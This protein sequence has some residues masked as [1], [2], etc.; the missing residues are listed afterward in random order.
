MNDK[1]N[2]ERL[3]N[4]E[5]DSDNDSE[6]EKEE[7]KKEAEVEN[8]KK[9][10]EADDEEEE[11]DQN[12]IN[13]KMTQ[14]KKKI[15]EADE[16]FGNSDS[17]NEDDE[18]NLIKRKHETSSNEDSEDDFFTRKKKANTIQ[19]SDDEQEE[20]ND[21][22]ESDKEFRLKKKKV[23]LI[24]EDDE[25]D[26]EDNKIEKELKDLQNDNDDNEEQNEEEKGKAE[27]QQK[28]QQEVDDSNKV[29]PDISSSSSEDEL[30][31]DRNGR[32]SEFVY[33][34][35]LMM[36][37]RKEQNARNRKRR[38]TDLI[39]DSD[40]FI[41]E[42]L[43]QMKH[44]AD[45]DFELNKDHKA[46][47]RKMKLL[48]TVATFL[49]KIDL[50]ESFLDSGVLSVITDWLTPLPDR[51]L[52]N[53]QIREIMLKILLELNIMDI[54]RLKSSSIGKAVMY[55]Y[56]HPKETKDNKRKA[57]QLISNWSRPIFNCETDY[58]A[59]SKEDRE[60][61]DYDLMHK[62]VQRRKGDESATSS[63]QATAAAAASSIESQSI[64]R[65]GEKGWMPR[66]RVPAPSTKDYVV[67]PKSTVDDLMP[68]T[69]SSR[70]QSSRLDKHLRS[71]Q[72]KKRSSKMQRAVKMSI[73]GRKI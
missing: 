48:P 24:E 26:Q 18:S 47:T 43:N 29:L 42:L 1:E 19:D 15:K 55:L 59:I 58:Q 25:D 34:F 69:K 38:N 62:V 68:I 66:A 35:D 31:G 22:K 17:E 44:A 3:S 52:P 7:D 28:Q 53:L 9:E 49:R 30:E 54:D 63:S 11:D 67:R 57:A 72:E 73:E 33:D 20:E 32:S 23:K 46:A 5:E 6:S 4:K 45:D 2:D 10:E 65:P 41:A 8:K 21:D 50:R 60:Q 14:M 13:A 27:K 71:F 64:L 39:N 56:K 36:A 16:I 70:K 40:D 12:E 37:K 51:S 61:R